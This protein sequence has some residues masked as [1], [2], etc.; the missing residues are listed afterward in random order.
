MFF[1]INLVWSR[2]V[3]IPYV[4]EKYTP[5]KILKTVSALISRKIQHIKIKITFYLVAE[6]KLPQ[7]VNISVNSDKVTSVN[8]VESVIKEP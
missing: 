3:Y 8:D 1:H 7:L 5:K 2:I 4:V 6:N